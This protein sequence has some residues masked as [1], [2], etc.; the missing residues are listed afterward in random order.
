MN[1]EQIDRF[2]VW[3]RGFCEYT[4]ISITE[5][6]A[7]GCDWVD[8]FNSGYVCGLL[9]GVSRMIKSVD[10]PFETLVDCETARDGLQSLFDTYPGRN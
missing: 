4:R 3:F 5:C 1:E 9:A 2:M 10:L 8:G 6:A 7:Q